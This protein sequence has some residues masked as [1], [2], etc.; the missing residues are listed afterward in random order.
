[1]RPAPSSDPTLVWAARLRAAAEEVRA[2]A[3][4]LAAAGGDVSLRGPAGSALHHLVD[5]VAA[6]VRGLAVACESAAGRLGPS[7]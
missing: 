6:D 2:V 5:A 3:A 7:S 1:M 4:A